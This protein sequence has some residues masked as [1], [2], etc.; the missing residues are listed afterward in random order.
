MI[1]EING[2]SYNF[3]NTKSSIELIVKEIE[4][5]VNESGLF[6]SHLIIDEEDIYDQF[7][8]QLEEKITSISQVKVIMKTVREFVNDLLLSTE[9]YLTG[10]LPELQILIDEL[11]QGPTSSSWEKL[12]QLLEGLQWINQL[13]DVIANGKYQPYNWSKYLKLINLLEN[14]LTA[15][16]AAMEANDQILIADILQYE[17]LEILS[18]LKGE[19]TAT[20]DQQGER[21]NVN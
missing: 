4:N 20:I 7:E 16:E 6:F 14:E 17:I 5:Q 10:A 19:A 2:K 11:Y 12:G 9:S 21:L 18:S 1:V 3:E 13:F 8:L 15:L